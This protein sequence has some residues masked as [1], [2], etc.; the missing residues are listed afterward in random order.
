MM[1]NFTG[2][3]IPIFDGKNPWVSCRFSQQ[4]QSN[5]HDMSMFPGHLPSE[6]HVPPPPSGQQRHL[7]G[8]EGDAATPAAGSNRYGFFGGDFVM[9]KHGKFH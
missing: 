3:E 7:R 5:A 6:H 8:A 4:N 2:K 1:G 9:G